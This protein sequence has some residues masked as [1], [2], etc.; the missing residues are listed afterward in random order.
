VGKQENHVEHEKYSS[1]ARVRDGKFGYC[2]QEVTES[3][4]YCKK[5]DVRAR[6]RRHPA[7]ARKFGF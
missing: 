3:G 1:Y 4:K 2:A 5:I 6:V 7:N